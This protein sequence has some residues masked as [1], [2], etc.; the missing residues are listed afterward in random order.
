M[1]RKLYVIAQTFNT[2][3]RYIIGATTD[4]N[5]ARLIA[6]RTVDGWLNRGYTAPTV[7]HGRTEA[8]AGTPAGV[9]VPIV[10]DVYATTRAGNRVVIE[11]YET[12]D[13]LLNE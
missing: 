7:Q 11:V 6:E 4:P 13:V 3:G 5:T 2:D 9:P 8:D 12:P 1:E 10:T